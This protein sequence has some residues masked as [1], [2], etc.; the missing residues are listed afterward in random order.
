MSNGSFNRVCSFVSL[1]A[2]DSAE[3]ERSVVKG[4]QTLSKYQQR[5]VGSV[6]SLYENGR[7]LKEIK[8]EDTVAIDSSRVDISLIAIGSLNRVFVASI[9]STRWD[10]P[11]VFVFYLKKEE[12]AEFQS[13]LLR[14]ENAILCTPRIRIIAY[15]VSEGCFFYTNYPINI[16]R[17]IGIRNTHTTHFIVLD[18][19]MWMG[20]N[21]YQQLLSLP[22]EVLDSYKTTVVIPAFFHTGW[23][24]VNG[25]FEE[26]VNSVRDKIPFTMEE[27]LKCYAE[28]RCSFQKKNLFT[29][30]YV[31]TKWIND[32]TKGVY[33][34]YYNYTCWKNYLQEPSVII[35]RMSRSYLLVRRNDSLTAF[36]E[37]FIN[38]GF[39]KIS[40]VEMLRR[41]EYRFVLAGKVF[42][43]DLPHLPSRYQK[44]HATNTKSGNYLTNYYY[45]QGLLKRTKNHTHI[46]P[47]CK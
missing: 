19:D 8:K 16:L 31:P 44:S 17:N 32:K 28:K 3:L 43:F 7:F 45:T 12:E 41:E 11:I 24:I 47:L 25:T 39:N 29:H 15:V 20:K 9:F 6:I 46:L 2:Q 1:Q 23:P 27:L 36:H 4:K 26:Q 35:N 18:M 5:E 34:D 13:L 40:F 14:P 21:S 38:Y 42:A 30:L 37:A 33:V 10:G 22:H